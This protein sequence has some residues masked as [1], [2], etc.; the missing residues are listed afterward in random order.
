MAVQPSL[1]GTRS[2]IPK[3]GFLRTR[4]IF[5]FTGNT[6]FLLSLNLMAL[7][8][9]AYRQFSD[10]NCDIFLDKSCDLFLMFAKNIHDGYTLEPPH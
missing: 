6:A 1:Y 3:T 2:E 4:L 10:K 7:H 9:H 8:K 5:D